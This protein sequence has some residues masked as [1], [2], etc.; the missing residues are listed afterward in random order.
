MGLH[1]IFAG[2]MAAH[3]PALPRGRSAGVKCPECEHEDTYSVDLGGLEARVPG[4]PA[5]RRHTTTLPSGTV[6]EW[7]TMSGADEE[8]LEGVRQKLNGE[9]QLTL[10]MLAR[11]DSLGGKP[12]IR[13]DGG[14]DLRRALGSLVKL[15]LRDRNA[16]R[17]AFSTHEGDLDTSLDFECK[18]CGHQFRAEMEVQAEGFFF[19]SET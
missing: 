13:S 3:F 6:V 15:S 17:H 12:I 18:R 11:I 7:H 1:P 14:T 19:P 16:I 8:W 2:I 9:G 10:A 4:D 5:K